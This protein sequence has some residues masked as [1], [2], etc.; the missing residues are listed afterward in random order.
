MN[1][2]KSITILLVLLV[3]AGCGGGKRKTFS[4]DNDIVIT[5]Q[6]IKEDATY[7]TDTT[8]STSKID[9]DSPLNPL[10]SSAA[11]YRGDTNRRFIK[12]ADLKFKVDN[13]ITRTYEIEDLTARFGGFITHTHLDSRI[14]G[15][16]IIPVSA[17]SSLETVY[18]TVT[19]SITLRVPER[20]LDSIL[21]AFTPM[22]EYLDHRTI[23]V[24]DVYIEM[25]MNELTQKRVRNQQQRIQNNVDHK[26][27]DLGDMNESEDMIFNRQA[28][29]DEAKINNLILKDQME[30]STV[31]L[32]IYQRQAIKREM[33]SN[34]KNIEAYEPGFGYKL[35]RSFKNGWKGFQ[36]III[37]F[38]QLWILLPLA[39]LGY[40][41]YR[42]I[43]RK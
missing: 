36:S 4:P 26:G 28:Q 11:T 37:F 25:L 23:D 9:I 10:S 13:V 5:P 16:T 43:R 21:R 32:L 38:A 12:T 2:T 42:V 39:L 18:Y 41:I 40:I 22:V 24:R 19:N 1:A 3:I 35:K 34:N 29:A 31:T 7:A 14:D 6:S 20:K 27:T 17:D 33:V 30:L 15:T 8:I